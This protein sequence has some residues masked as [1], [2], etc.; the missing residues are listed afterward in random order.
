MSFLT[1]FTSPKP[2]TDPHIRTIQRNALKSWRALGPE[3]DVILFG[4]DEGVAEAA[5]EFGMKHVPDV[6]TNEK[7]VPY[8]GDMFSHTRRLSDAPVLAI[9][10]TDIL[11]MPDFLETAKQA[12]ERFDNFVLVGR[13]WDLD[14]TAPL[15]F[16]PDWE[17]YL[18]ADLAE[19]GT[20]HGPTGSDYFLF[21]RETLTEVPDFTIGRAGWDNWMIHHAL[22]QPW[23]MLDATQAITIVHQNHD[24]SHLP[25]GQIHFTHPESHKNVSLGGGKRQ[26]S[27]LRDMRFAI[28]DGRE[29]RIP[30]TWLRFVR[31][32]ERWLMPDDKAAG[33]HG[34]LFN[35]VR[36]Y[37]K[38]LERA[39]KPAR[40]L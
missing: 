8:I 14:I 13:R 20:L 37:R 6:R 10:N 2:F 22:N 17:E 29:V 18:Q 4:D 38:K 5:A 27:D 19:R 9:L 25:G 26:M 3:V 32:M 16:S 40:K 30:L 23:N 39:G 35:A 28:I 21:S 1:L 33:L 7:G 15:D 12:A 36:R 24:Y 34:R 11:L 31:K